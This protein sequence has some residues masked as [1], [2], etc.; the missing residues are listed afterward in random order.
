MSLAAALRGAGLLLLGALVLF[1]FLELLAAMALP[2]P[3][4]DRAPLPKVTR[5][6]QLGYALV[7]EQQT[8][9]FSQPVTTNRLGLRERELTPG[10][11]DRV[12]LCIGGAETFGK[13][14][15]AEDTFPR[16]LE[17]LLSDAGAPV[18]INAGVPDYNVDQSVSYLE[19]AGLAFRPAVVVLAFDFS[20]LFE[21]ESL[22]RGDAPAEATGPVARTWFLRRWAEET[23]A[24]EVL[25]PIYTRSRVLHFGKNTAKRWLGRWRGHREVIW[26]DALLFGQLTPELEL[27]ME[28]V[29]GWLERYGALGRAHG[30]EAVVLIV[31]LAEQVERPETS[32]TFQATLRDRAGRHGLWILDAL[33]ALQAAREQR[34]F[35]P[36]DGRPSAVGHRILA[37]LLAA[38]LREHAHSRRGSSGEEVLAPGGQ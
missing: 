33:P 29:E 24:L 34:P 23:G 1:A 2:A 3:P 38:G 14:V 9:T 21:D 22:G 7:P 28:R 19:L 10:P 12:I 32:T 18:V 13:G 30:F 8:F 37:E 4:V 16:R 6:P 27:A 25:A 11:E 5:H 26:R 31:P 15:A 35:I 20:D 17:E 36:F